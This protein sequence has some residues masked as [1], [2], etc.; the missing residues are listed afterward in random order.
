MLLR[1]VLAKRITDA[2]EKDYIPQNTVL[3]IH[4]EGSIA[5][6][7]NINGDLRIST[8]SSFCGSSCIEK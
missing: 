7:P 3:S 5:Q 1:V 6:T 8:Y 2:E 4:E